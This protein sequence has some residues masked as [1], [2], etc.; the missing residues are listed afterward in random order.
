MEADIVTEI[1]SHSATKAGMETSLSS[2]REIITAAAGDDGTTRSYPISASHAVT[3]EINL[4]RSAGIDSLAEM[5][6]ES[7]TSGMSSSEE[8]A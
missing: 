4:A 7:I 5:R 6:T 8:A 2:D 1:R 3:S